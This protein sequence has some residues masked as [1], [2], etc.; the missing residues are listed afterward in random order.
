MIWRQ[1]LVGVLFVGVFA[2]GSLSRAEDTH[3]ASD[4]ELL[5]G[6]W[7]VVA[8]TVGLTPIDPK[9]NALGFAGDVV[10][11][12]YPDQAL[13]RHARYVLRP[14][15]TPKQIDV[16]GRDGTVQDLG[17]YELTGAQL[18]LNLHVAV[19]GYEVRPKT[20]TN[21]GAERNYVLQRKVGLGLTLLDIPTAPEGTQDVMVTATGFNNSSR[22]VQAKIALVVERGVPVPNV[23]QQ[24]WVEPQ[25]AR[26]VAWPSV[27]TG[28]GKIG[29]VL[30]E[31]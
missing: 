27:P 1:C 21:Q 22:R 24:V 6:H 16:L 13:S 4:S 23:V 31:D 8:M 14:D 15:K 20:F 12:L 28:K 10:T 25:S 17:I 2:F 29:V 30:L 3:Q 26:I 9:G 7:T 11:F 5:Q 18:R 19:R